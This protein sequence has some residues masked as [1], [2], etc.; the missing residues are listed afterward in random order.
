MHETTTHRQI[1][2]KGKLLTLE[3]HQ[4]ELADRQTAYREIIRHPGAIGVVARHPEGFFVFVRQFRKA[5][6][7]VMTEVVA[8]MLDPG[9]TP[10]TA[11]RR[12]LTEETGY[13]AAQIRHLGTL[14]ASPGYVDEKVEI[15]LADLHPGRQPLELDHGEHVEPIRM[16]RDEFTAAIRAGEIRDAKTLAAWAL[17]R[18]DEDARGAGSERA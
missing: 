10:E 17:F 8:G 5:V 14:F 11:A 7:C 16:S 1:A 13:Q 2:F 3:Q 6:E 12:E 9:E 18:E 15:F 4:V